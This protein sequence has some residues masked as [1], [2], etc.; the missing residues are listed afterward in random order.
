MGKLFKFEIRK[1]T[2]QKSFYI[3]FGISL[4]ILVLSAV[5]MKIA[6]NDAGSDAVFSPVSFTMSAIT[7]S[8][9]VMLL[10]IFTALYCCDD[11][12]NNTLKNIYSRGYSRAKVFFAKYVVSL[13]ASLVVAAAFFLI[14]FILGKVLGNADEAV[15][16]AFTGSVILQL[17]VIVGYH[18]VYFSL[19]MIIGK[20]GGS[21]AL[22]IVG[23]MLVLTVLTL[24][25]SLLKID[26]NFNEFWLDAV[27][28]PL[29]QGNVDGKIITKAVL[30]PIL[31]AGAFLTAGYFVNRKKE[32]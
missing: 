26:F 31:Y 13:L 4:L 10:G 21:V 18:A 1:I 19:A 27:M 17:L 25:A 30:M 15:T 20:V 32:M 3:C 22:N 7:S 28:N 11:N 29:S 16:G 14:S 2:R 9:Y 24:L 6:A 8:S 23:P 5:I 12:S